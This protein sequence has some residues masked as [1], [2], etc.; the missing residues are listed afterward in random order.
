MSEMK[1]MKRVFLALTAVALGS[2]AAAAQQEQ[3]RALRV[4]RDAVALAGEVGS[5]V[6]DPAP[7]IQED[8]GSRAYAAAREALNARRY[9]EAVEAFERLR[10]QYPRSAYLPDS[11]YYQAFALSRLGSRGQLR[12]ARELLRT[13]REQF[14]GGA[15]STLADATEL[16][17][18]IDAQLAGMGDV[19]AA[20]SITQQAQDPCG[21]DQE[22]RMAALNALLNMDAD[23]ATPILRQVLQD[24]DECSAEFRQQAV[25]LL[26]RSMDDSSVDVLLD[27][28]HRNPDPDPEVRAQ[29]VFWLSQVQSEEA[30]DALVDILQESD[31][32][33]VQENAL[34]A[35][36][37]HESERGVQILREFAEREDAPVQLRQNAIFFLGRS[38][39][40]TEYLKSLW[41]RAEAPELKE[42]ILHAVAQA[43]GE[44]SRDWLLDRV[45]DGSEDMEIRTHALFW[46]AQHGGMAM[47]DLRGL[48]DSFED[49][50][51]KEQVVFAAS[52]DDSREAVDFLMEVAEDRENGELREMAIFWLG[53]S[54]DPRVPEF[55][56]RIIGR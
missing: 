52:K 29:A 21:P 55:L 14:R 13:Q 56:L 38:S 34:F 26:A 37:R 54:K 44:E 11:Y 31:D 53:Q 19:R 5:P 23:R 43:E 25:F 16:L 30:V 35:L 20:Q 51:L 40:G 2:G 1:A 9:Q 12:E 4:S 10:T 41:G 45:R 48:F 7:W 49:Q 36:S 17:T 42:Q 46:V 33:E 50:E 28:A 27:L 39:V 24:K 3:T 15:T 8:P 47:A 6:Q 32:P 22:V 18:R